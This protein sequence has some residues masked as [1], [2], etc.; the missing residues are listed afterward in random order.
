M[1]VTSKT[2]KEKMPLI[3]KSIQDCDYYS[4]D[5][6]F[7]GITL[8]LRDRGHIYDT[9]EDR[10]QKLK[11][12]CQNYIAWQLGLSTF[13]YDTISHNYKCQTYSFPIFPRLGPFSKRAYIMSSDSLKF[14]AKH[15][16]AFSK[17]IGEG[18]VNSV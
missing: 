14:L 5:T 15:S 13:Q 2:F 18:I 9:M 3:L 6:E 8:N 16:F 1:E 7:S 17:T 10:Y 4:I 12:I 11:F